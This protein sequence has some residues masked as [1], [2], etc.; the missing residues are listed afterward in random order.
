M[1][2]YLHLIEP[3]R[4]RPAYDLAKR[5]VA[6]N[7]EIKLFDNRPFNVNYSIRV[8]VERDG[9]EYGFEYYID[10]LTEGVTIGQQIDAAIEKLL[11]G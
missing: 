6:E 8:R 5:L 7:V 2:E 3:T 10:P 11:E 1:R 4:T 9:K